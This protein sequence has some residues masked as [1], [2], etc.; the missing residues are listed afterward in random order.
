[1][2][3]YVRVEKSQLELLIGCAEDARSLL[4]DVHCYDTEIYENLSE[5]LSVISFEEIA[6]KNND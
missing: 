3:K 1:M 2:S 5:I 4:D 6:E